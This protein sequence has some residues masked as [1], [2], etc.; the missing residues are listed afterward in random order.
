MRRVVRSQT[1]VVQLKELLDQG[2]ER[3][4]VDPVEAKLRRIDHT[5]EVVLARHP[6]I[7]PVDAALQLRL[8]PI[9]DT[10]FVIL[11]DF[12]E[13]ELRLR[14]RYNVRRMVT[15]LLPVAL[16]PLARVRRLP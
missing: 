16:H 10:P 11:Y 15:Y 5:L 8:Y 3:F 4:G 12:T 9:T 13:T 6:K 1:Y 2:V 14:V 7:K